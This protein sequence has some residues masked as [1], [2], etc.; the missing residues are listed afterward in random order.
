[1]KPITTWEELAEVEA[2]FRRSERRMIINWLNRQAFSLETV[3]AIKKLVEKI[4]N[5]EYLK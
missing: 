4:E 1:M 3:G 5:M 2:I